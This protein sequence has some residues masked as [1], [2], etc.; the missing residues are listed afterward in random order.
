[1]FLDVVQLHF[2][3]F[4]MRARHPKRFR[5]RDDLNEPPQVAAVFSKILGEEIQNVVVLVP[6]D[7]RFVGRAGRLGL[8]FGNVT[9]DVLIRTVLRVR[10]VVDR[11]DERPAEHQTPDSIRNC[12][13]EAAVFLVR[14]PLGK[15][16]SR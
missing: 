13:V 12:A 8:R 14:N 3:G 5:F 1:M 7:F 15:L 4:G 16:L 2:V 9:N 6:V 11:R 10:H